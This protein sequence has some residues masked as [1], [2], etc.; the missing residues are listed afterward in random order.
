MT[1][2]GFCGC[3]LAPVGSPAPLL[4]RYAETTTLSRDGAFVRYRA[5]RPDGAPA[6]VVSTSPMVEPSPG[7]AAL[8]RLAL[9]HAA[10]DHPLLP[11]PRR[12]VD[13]IVLADEHGALVEFPLDVELDGTDVIQRLVAAR[14]S[15]R[16]GELEALTDALLDAVEH[17]AT[18]TGGHLWGLTLSS[19][20]VGRGGLLW[21]MGLGHPVCALDEHGRIATA[22][23]V[24]RAPRLTRGDAPSL[25][26][27]VGTVLE[28]RRALLPHCEHPVA[29]DPPS[30]GSPDAVRDGLAEARRRAQVDPDPA[31]L[32]RLLSELVRGL[33]PREPSSELDEPATEE[34][35]VV[36][37]DGS[38]IDGPT[39]RTATGAALRRVLAALLETHRGARQGPLDVWALLEAGWP[40]EVVHPEAGSNRVYV[41]VSRLRALGLRD[42]I[43]RDG[44]GYRIPH[45]ARIVLIDP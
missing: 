1:A 16:A 32:Q 37:A 14:A 5:R 13:E 40:H 30:D 24:F 12:E 44:D 4:D 18:T 17:A 38:W 29:F 26:T 28:L 39:G 8:Q 27:D 3:T 7:K 2:R 42:A 23:P 41:A 20:L 11:R 43:F 9:A 19:M 33:P 31:G 10:T 36:S 45:D 15:L 35:V 6:L 21:L 34:A 22:T 25:A